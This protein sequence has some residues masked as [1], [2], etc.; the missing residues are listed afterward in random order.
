MKLAKKALQ[1]FSYIAMMTAAF[2][3]SPVV[4][5]GKNTDFQTWIPVNIN[6]K[7]GEQLRGFLE[8]QPRIGDDSSHLTAMMIRPALGWAVTPTITLWAGYLM[9]VDAGKVNATQEYTDRYGIENRAWQGLTYK[10]M[11]ADKQ[12]IWEMRNRLEERFLSGNDDPSIR[13]RTRFR[14]EYIIPQFSALSLIASE[15]LF[16]NLDDNDTDRRVLQAGLNQN[17]AYIGMGYR[18]APEFQVETG[19][20]EQHVWRRA[21]SAD[22]NNSVWMTN[23]NINF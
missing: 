22:L 1:R 5:A 19:Y 7:L 3:V 21:G 11:T 6:L 4:H 14:F 2:T 16:I 15:E 10:D 23:L 9:S 17:R 20:L 18:F 13:W 12:F 8:F